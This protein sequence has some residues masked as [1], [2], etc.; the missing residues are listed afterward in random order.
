MGPVWGLPF[1]RKFLDEGD[2]KT[3]YTVTLTALLVWFI[4][5]AYTQFASF[6]ALNW[7][8]MTTALPLLYYLFSLWYFGFFWSGKKLERFVVSLGVSRQSKLWLSIVVGWAA[9][10]IVSI[11]YLAEFVYRIFVPYHD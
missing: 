8:F 2:R 5:F 3:R 6:N 4:F 1:V 11:M 7:S 10:S 9:L